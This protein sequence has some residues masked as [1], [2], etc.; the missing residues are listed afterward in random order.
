MKKLSAIL[1]LFSITSLTII[2]DEKEDRFKE[3]FCKEFL[4]SLSLYNSYKFSKLDVLEVELLK[5]C[6]DSEA[7]RDMLSKVR[8]YRQQQQEDN[9]YNQWKVKNINIRSDSHSIID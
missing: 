4:A 1:L 3:R 7:R 2:C 6:P 9:D 8:E 5:Y